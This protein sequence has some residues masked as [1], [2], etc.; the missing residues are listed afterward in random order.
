MRWCITAKGP[1]I[2]GP[3]YW[4]WS[5]IAIGRRYDRMEQQVIPLFDR[6]R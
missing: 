3:F 6:Q 1:A 5:L 2:A 4:Q